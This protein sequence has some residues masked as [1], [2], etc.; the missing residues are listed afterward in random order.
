MTFSARQ[1][2]LDLARFKLL[3][4]QLDTFPADA[5]PTD[6]EVKYLMDE[7][8]KIALRQLGVTG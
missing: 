3:F 2:S 5:D 8:D 1:T 7:I 6:P 4:E